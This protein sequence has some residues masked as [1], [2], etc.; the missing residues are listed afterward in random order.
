MVAGQVEYTIGPSALANVNT[1]RPLRLFDGSFIRDSTNALVPMDTPLRMISRFEYM[2]FGN[3]TSAGIPNSIYYD[4]KIADPSSFVDPAAA[5]TTSPSTPVA[6]LFVYTT[7]QTG[8]N[9][10]IHVNAQRPLFAFGATSSIIDAAQEF[11][12]PQEWYLALLNAVAAD[13]ADDYEVPEQRIARLEAARDRYLDGLYDWSVETPS[14]T[15]GAQI[16]GFR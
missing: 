15:F 12:F 4:S 9:R 13:I 14:T 5:G 3:K 2:Q 11:D 1:I 8:V 6:S 7:M 16:Q 10:T